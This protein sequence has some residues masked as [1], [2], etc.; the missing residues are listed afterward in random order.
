MN[1]RDFQLCFVFGSKLE[2]NLSTQNYI[3]VY[4]Y[5]FE[6]FN[7]KTASVHLGLFG[8]TTKIQYDPLNMENEYIFCIL[9]KDNGIPLNV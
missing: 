3:M 9:V 4:G 5:I 8:K 7:C 2:F 1:T 6:E